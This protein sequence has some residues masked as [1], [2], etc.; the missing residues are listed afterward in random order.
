MA[1][2]RQ[3]VDSHGQSEVAFGLCRLLN[4]QLFP[5]LKPIH[6]QKLYLPSPA[7]MDRYP[8]IQPVLARA[9]NWTLIRHQYDEMVKYAT[10]LRS[11]I[12]DAEAILRRFTRQSGHPTYKAFAELGRVMKTIF[13][14][15][16]LHDEALRREIH[17][18]LNVVEDWNSA[19]SFIFYGQHGELT[20]NRRDNQEVAMLALHLLQN[21]L[22]SINTLMIQDVLAEPAWMER[23]TEADLRALTPLIYHHVNPYG[24]F[25]H[26]PGGM[27]KL[28]IMHVFSMSKQA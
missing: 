3:Y 1:I 26:L 11:G 15:R 27:N 7:H 22:V 28:R 12:A 19:N 17:E 4:F 6:S 21:C 8:N 24:T 18:G 10:A 14:C 23:M 9:I 13:L 20:T 5:R 16:Y 2:D 25:Y